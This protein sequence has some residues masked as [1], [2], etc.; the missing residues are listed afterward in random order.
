LLD[1]LVPWSHAGRVLANS[2]LATCEPR[3]SGG[4]TAASKGDDAIL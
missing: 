4:V 3:S 1:P 2:P